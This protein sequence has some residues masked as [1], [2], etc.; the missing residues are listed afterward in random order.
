MTSEEKSSP[1]RFGGFLD[2]VKAG[3][4]AKITPTMGK[5]DS[6]LNKLVESSLK[7][8]N[9]DDIALGT[10]LREMKLTLDR[11]ED[12][13]AKAETIGQELN[14]ILPYA[15]KTTS[16]ESKSM[17]KAVAI[18]YSE[19]ALTADDEKLMSLAHRLDIG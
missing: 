19:M 18:L 8:N 5:I 6:L 3:K 10:S 14:L 4:I 11:Q 2:T 9:D 16:E 7:S 15:K 13:L 17:M 1:S 12:V